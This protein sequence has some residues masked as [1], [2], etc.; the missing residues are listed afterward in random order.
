M[1]QFFG[2]KNSDPNLSVILE[3]ITNHFT[4][5]VMIQ[6]YIPEILEGDKRILVING[7]PMGQQLQEYLLKEN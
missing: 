5:K 4:Q 2:L 6:E 1:L 3:T 7:K